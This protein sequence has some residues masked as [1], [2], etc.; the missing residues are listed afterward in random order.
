MSAV[1]IEDVTDEMMP[2]QGDDPEVG[3]AIP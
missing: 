3:V 1:Y 2:V